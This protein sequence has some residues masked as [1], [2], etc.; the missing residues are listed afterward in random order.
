MKDKPKPKLSPKEARKL[1]EQRF[2]KVRGA[3]AQ[4][5]RALVA[6]GRQV[7]TLINGFASGGK[8]TD[9]KALKG[10]LRKYSELLKPWARLVTARM[11]RQVDWR[12]GTSWLELAREMGKTLR[13]EIE[14]APTG[15]L[16]RS[17]MSAQAE[18][19]TSLPLEAAQRV[20]EFAREAL[21]STASRADVLAKEILRSGAVTAA[22]AR[23]IARTETSRTAALLMEARARHIGSTHYV[24][25]T[26]E[27][28]DVRPEHRKLNRRVFAW[29]HPPNAGTIGNPMYY[30]PGC[31]PN[32]FTGET[33][34]T[35]ANGLR[36]L[37]RVFHNGE[38]ID[39][40]T[41]SR[42]LISTTPNHPILTA[43]G[44]L[45]ARLIENGDDLVCFPEQVNWITE[46]NENQVIPRFQDFFAT[47]AES[48]TL[49][50]ANLFQFHGDVF[51]GDVDEIF[52][53][54]LL[55]FDLESAAFEGA[56]ELALTHPYTRSAH[57]RSTHR[58]ISSSLRAGFLGEL[59][60][61]SNR[62]SLEARFIRGTAIATL[63]PC[64]QEHTLDQGP[65][66]TCYLSDFQF[67]HEPQIQSRDRAD[68]LGAEHNTIPRTPVDVGFNSTSP[69]QLA[70]MVRAAANGGS[71][72]FEH[73]TRTYKFLR[74]IDKVSRDFSGHVFTAET[75]SGWYCTSKAGIVSLNCRCYAE[76]ILL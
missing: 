34:F 67:A 29:Q 72:I 48:A 42:D 75:E 8:V 4:Y 2:L 60:E 13:T 66:Q 76:P 15:K 73:G 11:H 25:H 49:V 59:L 28:A 22:R 26:S 3:E 74:I 33:R 39:L 56:G 7:G 69:Q 31:G 64:I 14:S 65:G 46:M 35:V 17:L 18:L 70:Q 45:P 9:V 41:A 19:I 53:A 63:D 1:A 38:I 16:F 47:H 57:V 20:Q 71:R 44:W 5:Q 40:K 58:Q 36:H 51:D 10:A 68:S 12:D 24:W 54:T 62:H 32:C 43:R 6:V 30:N 21:V 27:D 55:P 50:P 37:W 61:G 52:F 23:L